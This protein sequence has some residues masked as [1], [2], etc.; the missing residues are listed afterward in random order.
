MIDIG[1]GTSYS[2]EDPVS[3]PGQ[4]AF[5]L[6]HGAH[7]IDRLQAAPALETAQ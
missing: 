4:N 2:L 1:L 6:R 5:H 3:H 7:G